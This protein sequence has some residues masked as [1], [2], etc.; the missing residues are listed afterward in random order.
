MSHT[1]RDFRYTTEESRGLFEPKKVGLDNDWMEHQQE[2]VIR[3]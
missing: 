1:I 3:D 2:K